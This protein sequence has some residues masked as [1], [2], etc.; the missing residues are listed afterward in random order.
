MFPNLKYRSKPIFWDEKTQQV[1]SSEQITRTYGTLAVAKNRGFL[2]F[3]STLEFNVYLRLVE[4]FGANRVLRQYPLRIIPPGYCYKSG[5]KWR[6]DFAIFD[7]TD[8]KFPAHFIE[9]KGAVMPDFRHCIASLESF[10]PGSFDQLSIVFGKTI[11]PDKMIKNLLSTDFKNRIYTLKE[12]Q[13]TQR[14]R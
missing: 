4:M 10:D 5:K 6:V 12:L 7:G 1:T 8:D 11:P 14:L 2:R 13:C 3:D 9:A